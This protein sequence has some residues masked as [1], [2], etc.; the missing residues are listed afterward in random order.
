MKVIFSSAGT[1]AP[2][3]RLSGLLSEWALHH[4]NCRIFA[5]TAD[6]EA[7]H[8]PFANKPF[9]DPE[10]FSIKISE[11]DLFV[12]HAGMGNIIRALEAGI[13]TVVL[14]RRHALGEHVNDHQL[15][16]LT[17]FKEIPGI[18]PCFGDSEEF[19]KAMSDALNSATRDSLIE[20]PAR[21]ELLDA[22]HAFL[23]S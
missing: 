21:Q 4:S 14:P 11:S 5:Q 23:K 15:D 9:I 7:T 3:P 2:F 1:Q 10:T 20:S 6:H 18:F 13:P 12:T 22:V 8:L 19:E 16:T 17:E